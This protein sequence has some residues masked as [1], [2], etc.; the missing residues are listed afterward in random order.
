[1]TTARFD[2]LLLT[3][4]MI[5][6]ILTLATVPVGFPNAPRIPVWSLS[7][8]AHDNI[9]LILITWY[10]CTLT[11]R[12]NESLPDIF[13]IYL[14]AQIRP[15]SSAS[16]DSCSYSSEIKCTHSGKSSTLAFLRP[17]S[18]ILIFGSCRRKFY[19]YKSE[20]I[21]W[22]SERQKKQRTSICS[23]TWDTTTVSALWVWFILTVSVATSWTA[24][25][26]V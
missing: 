14:L 1:M 19:N 21:L 18:K 20:L 10:G 6:P 7:A 3:E 25:H 2:S 8:P 11:L 13:V 17:R 15:A 12:W 4:K 23:L 16:E 26:T 9:L 5:C 22:S 24:S